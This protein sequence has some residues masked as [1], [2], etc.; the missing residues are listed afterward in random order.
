MNDV[1]K[2]FGI[3]PPY[4]Y[5]TNVRKQLE[6]LGKQVPGIV[7]IRSAMEQPLANK[8]EYERIA[9]LYLPIGEEKP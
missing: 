2:M 7:K 3:E 1:D 9:K 5:W 4:T 8:L 6:R